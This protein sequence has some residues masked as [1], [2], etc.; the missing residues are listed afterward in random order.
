MNDREQPAGDRPVFEPDLEATYTIDRVVEITG[1]T[2]TTILHFQEQGLIRPVA[3]GGS[4]AAPGRFDDEA[5]R[6]LRRIE[7]LRTQ[8]G[9]EGPGLALLVHLLDEV[10]RLRTD[11]RSRHGH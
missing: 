10:E 1:I 3:A 9:I 5:L 4:G 6:R 11:L 8:C 2:S 7:H